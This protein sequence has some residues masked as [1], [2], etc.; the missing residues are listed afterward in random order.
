VIRGYYLPF[1][2]PKR[3]P[4]GT[5]RDVTLVEMSLLAGK[6]RIWG[7]ASFRYWAHFD[8][9]RPLKH[10]ALIVDVGA[11]VKPFITPDDP[12]RVREI[13][14]SRGHRMSRHPE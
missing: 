7:T 5:I 8:P 13:L 14:D 1:G 11:Y 2:P 4:Y 6:G 12:V 9:R 10:T 3:I